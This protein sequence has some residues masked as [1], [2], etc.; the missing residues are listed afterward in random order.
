MPGLTAALCLA[1]GC[2]LVSGCDGA[3][4]RSVR[5]RSRHCMLHVSICVLPVPRYA[6]VRVAQVTVATGTPIV[7]TRMPVRRTVVVTAAVDRVVRVDGRLSVPPAS[8]IVVTVIGMS[9]IAMVIDVQA[10][11]CPGDRE[12]R[13]YA[14]KESAMERVGIRIRVV[15]H[16]ARAFVIEIN[17]PRLI[18]DNAFR[19][20]IGNVNDVVVQRRDF[21]DTL[22]T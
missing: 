22:V 20:V 13:R 12:R 4:S 6:L 9:I 11:R 1:T 18:N 5:P 10:V 14:P 2:V 3:E 19:L 7:A 21:N 15:I 17:R 8:T 16:R